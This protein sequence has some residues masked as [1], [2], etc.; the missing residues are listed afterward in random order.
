MNTLARFC[1][2]AF[3]LGS[4]MAC[5]LLGGT[6]TPVPTAVP[7]TLVPATSAATLAATA[8]ATAASTAAATTAASSGAGGK[9]PASCDAIAST[10]GSYMG[11]VGSTKSLATDHLSCEFA[12]TSASTIVILNIGASNQAAFDK[13]RTETAQ[14]SRT[15]KALSG[16]GGQALTVYNNG[17]VAGITV[18]SDQNVLYVLTANLTLD[19]DE[20]LVK[21]LMALS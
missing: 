13:L 19:Q 8:A 5:S 2:A 1:L 7:P 3:V 16:M 15:V 12:N 9:V 18:L 11:G 17:K 20:A 10:V 4:V 6:A 21:Q 14:G